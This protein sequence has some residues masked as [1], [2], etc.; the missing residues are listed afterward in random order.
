MSF[1]SCGDNVPQALVVGWRGARVRQFHEADSDTERSSR[2]VAP[3]ECFSS[4][5]VC[6]LNNVCLGDR[7]FESLRMRLSFHRA[8]LARAVVSGSTEAR[9]LLFD[10]AT[11]S[12]GA[13][14]SP[15]K[16]YL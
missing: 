3:E 9:V 5:F 6:P 11:P 2:A 12:G 1:H 16:S 7:C 10:G 4:A 8:S 15:P 13:K 14:R